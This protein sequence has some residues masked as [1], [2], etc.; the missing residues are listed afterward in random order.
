MREEAAIDI[1]PGYT[2]TGASTKET[3]L[4]YSAYTPPVAKKKKKVERTRFRETTR[5][6]RQK[7]AQAAAP[8]ASATPATKKN[9]ALTTQKA[10]KKEKIRFG[11]APSKTLPAAAGPK[12]R[13]LGVAIRL[14]APTR[15]QIRWRRRKSL[16]RRPASARA[17]KP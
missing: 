4:T 10:G 8:A 15:R 9:V 11:Q 6:Y 7:S 1:K 16:R 14:P 13:M 2:D 5:T 3:K 12:W 17:R